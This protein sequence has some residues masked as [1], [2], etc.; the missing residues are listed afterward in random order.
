MNILVGTASWTDKSLI[1]SGKFY[2]PKAKTAEAR[3]RYYASLFP[4]VE[5]DS[6]YYA[7]P[8]ASTAQLWAERT[9]DDFVFNVKSFRLFTGH[10]TEPKVLHTDIRKA[11]PEPLASKKNLYYKDLPLPVLDELWRRFKECLEPLAAAG[12]LGAVHFQF[13]PWVINNRDGHAHVREC[14]ERM[15]DQL[16]AVE[17]RNKTWLDEAHRADTL[18]FEREL[19]VA[20]VIVDSPTHTYNSVEPVWDISST[21][22]ALL[23]LHGRNEET[24]NIKGE[25]ASDRFNY[26]Y[27]DDELRELVPQIRSIAARVDAMHI[28]FNVNKEDQGQ[29]NALTLMRLLAES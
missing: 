19:G 15:G 11:L 16:L 8:S 26:D 7:M 17:F 12:K 28:V 29:R 18:E 6:S 9:P 21:R 10:A 1:A 5:V 27:T 23:R 24:W 13:A 2:P 25:A 14:V 20:H 22:L 3:L 4:M